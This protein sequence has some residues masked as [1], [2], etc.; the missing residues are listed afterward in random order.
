MGGLRARGA[1]ESLRCHRGAR[2][3]PA[4]AWRQ[5]KACDGHVPMFGNSHP[6]A[7]HFFSQIQTE[8]SPL[9]EGLLLVIACADEICE[10]HQ[11]RGY[12][13]WREAQ[14]PCCRA[15]RRPRAMPRLVGCPE[16]AVAKLFNLVTHTNTLNLPWWEVPGADWQRLK[17]SLMTK[18]TASRDRRN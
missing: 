9:Q 16:A 13:S 1:S 6:H 10:Q 8:S 17:Q 12:T 7:T 15:R 3:A 5:K 14:S 18:K 4:G 2:E 11:A